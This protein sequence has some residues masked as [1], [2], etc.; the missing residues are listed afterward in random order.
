MKNLFIGLLTSIVSIHSFANF[1]TFNNLD[2]DFYAQPKNRTN[3]V[4]I[5]NLN[6]IRTLNIPTEAKSDFL[7]DYNLTLRDDLTRTKL[8][9]P[10]VVD[11][12]AVRAA[13]SS[14]YIYTKNSSGTI[15]AKFCDK[16]VIKKQ[17]RFSVPVNFQKEYSK[18]SNKDNV[19]V[20]VSLN[21]KLQGSIDIKVNY[22][23]KRRCHIE[24][25]HSYKNHEIDADISFNTPE[26]D[27]VFSGA[28]LSEFNKRIYEESF[29]HS[30]GDKDFWL[31]P[32]LFTFD[33]KFYTLA[34]LDLVSK[35]EAQFEVQSGLEGRIKYGRI[36]TK[37][38]CDKRI[39][40]EGNIIDDIIEF[41]YK[42]IDES[43]SKINTNFFVDGEFK[44]IPGVELRLDV[45]FEI[46]RIFNPVDLR[47]ALGA[48][49]PVTF[50]YYYGNTCGDG[51]WDGKNELARG[52]Y[53]DLSFNI[54]AYAQMRVHTQRIVEA[55][56]PVGPAVVRTFI[57]NKEPYE[58]KIVRWDGQLYGTSL[59]YKELSGN[60]V[61][62][63]PIVVSPQNI[64]PNSQVA[65]R[66]RSCYPYSD[67]VTY[68]IQWG[69]TNEV[70]RVT[71]SPN[72]IAIE[73]DWKGLGTYPVSVRVIDDVMGRDIQSN[74]TKVDVN[75]TQYGGSSS[76]PPQV[77]KQVSNLELALSNGELIKLE[78]DKSIFSDPNGD[79][80]IFELSD[81]YEA[82]QNG[83]NEGQGFGTHFLRLTDK[84]DKLELSGREFN[85]QY[86]SYYVYV[87]AINSSGAAAFHRVNLKVH[88]IDY[89]KPKLTKGFCTLTATYTLSRDCGSEGSY[90]GPYAA[91]KHGGFCVESFGDCSVSSEVTQTKT[92]GDGAEY[93]GPNAVN[94]HWGSCVNISGGYNLNT[95][96]TL[97]KQCNANE[98]YLGAN[99]ANKHGGHCVSLTD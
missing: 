2:D 80:L 25:G 27:L 76:L 16:K 78:I 60:S 11:L 6:E 52:L 48:S 23:A 79:P 47:V 56:L 69:D 93:I 94:K 10:I 64:S 43:D 17:K 90:V 35:L 67:N 5:N 33:W 55:L 12:N 59:F 77:S 4:Y 13:F 36:C 34:Y 18:E 97:T 92:C 68:E 20:D 44:A 14:N 9:S 30:K 91:N 45:D 72:G 84:G 57:N 81:G 73:H 3:V 46:Y 65:I 99:A 29:V 7:S 85:S 49:V 50:N 8:D 53:S 70:E 66:M 26:K 71:G 98:I 28:V 75:I 87:K 31:G 95:R 86:N 19:N 89:A 37:R 74:W 24:Y 1:Q 82:S 58:D 38:E 22:T 39:D 41:N 51:N 54:Y 88:R 15:E 63:T 40:S 42:N 21:M 32:I 62:L 96:Y 61:A 83:P